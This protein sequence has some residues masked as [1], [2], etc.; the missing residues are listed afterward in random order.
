MAGSKTEIATHDAATTEPGKS[1]IKYLVWIP[2]IILL[3]IVIG[4]LLTREGDLKN[5][6]ARPKI[7]E[8][9]RDFTYP[10]LTG[11]PV[12]LSSFY[13]KKVVFVNIWATWCTACKEEMP[14]MQALYER[15][16]G[17]DFEILA[18]SIDALGAKAIIPYMKDM[19]LTFPA[20]QDLKGSIQHLYGTTGV[21]E[22]FV[23]DKE[24]KIA[25][26]E[27]GPGDWRETQ[28]QAFIKSLMDEPDS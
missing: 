10:D 22:S 27:V 4:T 28:K 11:K 19:G 12:T 24:G 20:L 5:R 23:V 13:G 7:G 14:T 3:L 21:P 18:V 6:K 26:V 8:P 17:D 2:I 15:F 16:K 1:F 9:A 25:L